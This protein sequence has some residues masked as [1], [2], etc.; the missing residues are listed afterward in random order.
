MVCVGFK[1]SP[2]TPHRR[3]HFVI[4]KFVVRAPVIKVP[5]MAMLGPLSVPSKCDLTVTAAEHLDDQTGQRLNASTR[6]GAMEV[7]LQD[8][9][10][11]SR[12]CHCVHNLHC[13]LSEHPRCVNVGDRQY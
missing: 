9:P 11:R 10:T 1:H 5:G 13:G 12:P 8:S 7:R 4:P 6:D 2:S 3:G